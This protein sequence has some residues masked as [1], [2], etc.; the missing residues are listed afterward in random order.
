MASFTGK[1][2][3]CDKDWQRH[4]MGQL[5]SPGTPVL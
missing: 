5:F 4:V 1:Q 2:T 3:L